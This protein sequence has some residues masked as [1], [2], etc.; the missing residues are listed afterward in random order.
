MP[1]SIP[2]IPESFEK[3]L[4]VAISNNPELLRSKHLVDVRDAEIDT[5]TSQL[6]PQLDINGSLS[7]RDTVQGASVVESNN[8]SILLNLTIPIY[9][10]GNTY[11]NIREQKDRYTQSQFEYQ[12]TLNNVK[13]EV[14]Q[15][16]QNLNTTASN[17]EATKASLVASEY[18]LAGVREEQKE[19]A[20]LIL[21]VLDAEQERF[22]S[23]ISHARAIKDS[24]LA[25]YQLKSVMGQLTPQS[26]ALPIENYDPKK[27]YENTKNKFFGLN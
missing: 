16:W 22:Q 21:D 11:S 3:V 13:N 18:A 14:I 10:R 27:H 17:I 4:S 25:I 20:R 1:T 23:E 2:K 24:V 26:L 15:S 19:G 6:Y 8:D 5:E 9:N 7:Q 12:S